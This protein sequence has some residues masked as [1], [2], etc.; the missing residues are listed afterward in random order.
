MEKSLTGLKKCKAFRIKGALAAIDLDS[1][2]SWK[3]FWDAG[4]S[5]VAQRNRI[6]LAPHL[7]L[8]VDE[9]NLSFKKVEA[10]IEQ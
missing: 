10:L 8:T 6:I 3:E 1:P 4:I 5:L 9:W 2:P 7:T